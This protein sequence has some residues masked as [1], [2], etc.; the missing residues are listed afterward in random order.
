M[1][2]YNHQNKTKIQQKKIKL[3]IQSISSENSKK[4]TFFMFL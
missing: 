2:I 1:Q 3:K 4:Q